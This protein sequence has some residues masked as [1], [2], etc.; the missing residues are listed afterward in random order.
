MSAR[1]GTHEIRNPLDP[2]PNS[3]SR[4][5]SAGSPVGAWA[6]T[7]FGCCHGRCAAGHNLGGSSLNLLFRRTIG[8][9]NNPST[10]RSI[11]RS[12]SL[13][14]AAGPSNCT[15]PAAGGAAPGQFVVADQDAARRLPHRQR[16]GGGSLLYRFVPLI[17]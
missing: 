5:G 10:A 7:I 11:S 6:A 3:H 8:D 13:A 12:S 17:R 9:P 2:D 16:L 1:I 4:A 15:N 14:S